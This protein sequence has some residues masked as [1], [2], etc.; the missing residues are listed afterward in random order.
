MPVPQRHCG[1]GGGA[2][3]EA[4]R[5]FH[6]LARAGARH[7]DACKRS[8]I[9]QRCRILTSRGRRFHELPRRR[10]LASLKADGRDRLERVAQRPLNISSDRDEQPQAAR[11]VF[12][13]RLRFVAVAYSHLAA[14]LTE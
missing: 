3:T 14:A 7:R 6:L 9:P 10:E 1:M 4:A 12:L 13:A 11:L 5:Q 8:E 2:G